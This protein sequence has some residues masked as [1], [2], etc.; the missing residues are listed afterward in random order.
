MPAPLGRYGEP[1]SPLLGP[2]GRSAVPDRWIQAKQPAN[3]SLKCSPVSSSTGP[4]VSARSI[5]SRGRNDISLTLTVDGDTS[6]APALVDPSFDIGQAMTSAGF[7]AH[8]GRPG[9]WGLPGLGDETTG[10]DLLVPGALAGPGRRGTRVPGQ[11]RH[12][13]EV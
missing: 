7:V 2:H 3:F 9:I 8:P 10:F 13:N 5:S 6:V 11:D 12:A 1:S 4:G